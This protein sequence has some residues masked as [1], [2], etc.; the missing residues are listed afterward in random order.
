[1]AVSRINDKSD[2]W[3]SKERFNF[4]IITNKLT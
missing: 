2:E 4:N 1:M 3:Y